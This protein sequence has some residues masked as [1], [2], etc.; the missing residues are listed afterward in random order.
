MLRVLPLW[1]AWPPLPVPLDCPSGP[2]PTLLPP[3]L[4][5]EEVSGESGRLASRG[6][7][8][9]GERDRGSRRRHRR[10]SGYTPMFSIL[11]DSALG[12]LQCQVQGTCLEPIHVGLSLSLTKWHV[13][14]MLRVV[15]T[16]IIEPV[17][18]GHAILQRDIN[19]QRRG[20]PPPPFSPFPYDDLWECQ[21][22]LDKHFMTSVEND[23]DL[24]SRDGSRKKVVK[25]GKKTSPT[26]R[27][28][29]WSFKEMVFRCE[30]M[31]GRSQGRVVAVTLVGKSIAC[32]YPMAYNPKGG[33]RLDRAPGGEGA[34]HKRH[35]KVV[36]IRLQTSRERRNTRCR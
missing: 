6:R 34:P 22:K 4:W 30:T 21:S 9:M 17:P 13:N 10:R 7:R 12:Q 24:S 20:F 28:W 19:A 27:R 31:G 3:T 26:V 1:W 8:R 36:R 15:V 2:R 5:R 16:H 29:A 33:D 32:R 35:C 11:M 14:G 18:A 25:C 23:W